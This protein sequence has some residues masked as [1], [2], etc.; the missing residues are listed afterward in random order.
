MVYLIGFIVR[1][2]LELAASNIIQF[3]KLSFFYYTQ[4]KFQFQALFCTVSGLISK[5]KPGLK[6]W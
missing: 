5:K 6:S 3:A 4:S 1:L 2:G